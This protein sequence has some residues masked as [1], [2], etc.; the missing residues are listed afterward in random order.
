MCVVVFLFNVTC[1]GNI[2]V[3][4]PFSTE[5]AVALTFVLTLV[6][7]VVIGVLS[8][9]VVNKCRSS[10]RITEAEIEMRPPPAIYDNPEDFKPD[11]QTQGNTAYGEVLY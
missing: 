3:V 4:T 5:A 7:G 11:P 10:E 9:L 8:V 1:T 6:L 2:F